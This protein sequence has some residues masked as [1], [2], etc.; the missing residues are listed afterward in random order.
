[1]QARQNAYESAASKW[2]GALRD[3]KLKRAQA[4]IT[5][6]GS[7]A[8][9]NA[10]ADRHTI[11]VGSQEEAEYVALKAVMATLSERGSILQSILRAQ[12]V[13]FR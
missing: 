2:V 4:F 6:Q 12:Q 7:V 3:Q 1:M 11:L 13:G 5:A 9:R 10:V 8:E